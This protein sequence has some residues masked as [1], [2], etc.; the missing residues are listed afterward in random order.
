[1]PQIDYGP[2][3]HRGVTRL[4]AVGDAEYEERT[5][6]IV[7]TGTML[8]GAAWLAGILTGSKTLRGMGAGATAALLAVRFA[9]KKKQIVIAAPP[10]PAAISGW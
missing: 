8:A 3:G 2:P 1:M 6:G 7:R 5:D 10:A 9:A 4:V